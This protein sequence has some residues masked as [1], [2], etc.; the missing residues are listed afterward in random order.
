MKL[1]V[2]QIAPD[3][4]L[5]AH[6]G[7]TLT[8]SHLRGKNVVMVFYPQAWTPVWTSQIPSYEA[9]H[10]K[11]AGLDAQVLGISIDH[12]PCIKAWAESLGGINYPLLSDFWPHGAVTEKYDVFRS[13]DGYSE[14]AIFIIDKQGV[15]RYIDVHDIDQQPENEVVRDILRKIDPLAAARQP[16]PTPPPEQAELPHGGIIMY[17][18]S[19][20]PACRRAR[21][22]FNNRDLKFTEIDIDDNAAAAAQVKKW[23]NGNRST[24]AFDIDG[25]ILTNFD[26]NKLAE[27]VKKYLK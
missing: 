20:C 3:F 8:L 26:E 19:W 12:I 23:N 4:T 9:E 21:L 5:P 2:G 7:N 6:L 13:K 27:A 24:P 10:A 17:C 14:R 22:W 15:I 11:F 16:A 25:T 18:T 1:K